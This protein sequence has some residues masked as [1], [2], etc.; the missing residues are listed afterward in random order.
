MSS[1]VRRPV[2]LK[3]ACSMKWQ[4][5]FQSAGSWREPRLT[6]MP[7]VAERRNGIGSVRTVSPLGSL[8]N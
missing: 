1:A 8:V 6:Q 5:P 3:T 2:P 4:T 7:T